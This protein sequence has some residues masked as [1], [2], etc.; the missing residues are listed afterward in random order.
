MTLLHETPLNE[1]TLMPKDWLQR[2]LTRMIHRGQLGFRPT[3]TIGDVARWFNVDHIWLRELES[4]RR[5]ISD[6]WQIQ[7]S[8]FFYLLDMGF[9]E[10]QVDSKSR[11]KSWVRV[12][13][14]AAP[15]CKEARPRIDFATAKLKFD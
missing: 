5:K 1:Q 8:Q 6:Q 2:R 10:L 12:T 9:I 15:P 14:P 13:M 4:G 3:L 11:R 7:L